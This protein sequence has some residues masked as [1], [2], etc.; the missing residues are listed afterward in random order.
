MLT[1]A[2]RQ[3]LKRVFDIGRPADL[4]DDS[5]AEDGVALADKERFRQRLKGLK[6]PM[7]ELDEGIA[8]GRFKGTSPDL[9]AT[10]K[11][12]N[13]ARKQVSQ[14]ETKRHW[15]EGN[16][17]LDRLEQAVRQLATEAGDRLTRDA[18]EQQLF[19]QRRRFLPEHESLMGVNA[20]PLPG[21]PSGGP[22]VQ[23]W[24]DMRAAVDAC[25]D[26]HRKRDFDAA[27][28]ELKKVRDAVALLNAPPDSLTQA[29]ARRDAL[30]VQEQRFVQ[31]I[32][33]DLYPGLDGPAAQFRAD[34]GKAL[35][36]ADQAIQDQDA[37]AAGGALDTAQQA[38]D[39][40]RA[41]VAGALETAG[42]GKHKDR[43][44]KQA[45]GA[46]AQDPQTLKVLMQRAQGPA[47]IDAMMKALGASAKSAEDKEF[48]KAAILARFDMTSLAGD[49]TTKALPKLYEVLAS[50]PAAHTT[51][52]PQLQHI[53][54]DRNSNQPS[55]YG[56]T[57]L[58]LNI[59]K[60]GSSTQ[61]LDQDDDVKASARLRKTE[62]NTFSHTTLHELGHSV[63]DK[64]GFMGT[65]GKLASYGG[66][67]VHT[68]DELADVAG[69][70]KKFYALGDQGLP[71]AFLREL[72]KCTLAGQS[73]K[74]PPPD[75]LK[76]LSI[77]DRL[78]GL[79]PP[80]QAAL[81]SDKWVQQAQTD[82]DMLRKA[83]GGWDAAVANNLRNDLRRAVDGYAPNAKYIC[84]TI[85]LIF[86]R[87]M[88]AREAAD[89]VL[90]QVV[91]KAPDGFDLDTLAT[92]DAVAWCEWARSH[93]G[94]KYK[95][96]KGGPPNFVVN[97]RYYFRDENN[98]RSYLV[99]ARKNGVSQYQFKAPAE[100]FAEL[101]AAFHL[102][103]LPD[104]HPDATWLAASYGPVAQ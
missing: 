39:D 22:L 44:L 62:V 66:W 52:N 41:A 65:H 25:N 69:T 45:K 78:G 82:R 8:G 51:G 103:K 71:I 95:Y 33:G 81:L 13:L 97:G 100:W 27:L 88:S 68:I 90:D 23:V 73:W 11:E 94:D 79:A 49:L 93:P 20:P 99:D 1:K 34:V 6:A 101:Y 28:K 35:K 54:R 26:A 10:V 104:T 96:Y 40:F 19:D 46:L 47:A 92:H 72:L 58:T 42:T 43:A 98:W 17:A 89:A 16:E 56:E 18:K 70:A 31:G 7:Q 55:T 64:D 2:Q 48:A 76:S 75:V 102:K 30:R 32:D 3:W 87:Q 83:D 85:E 4:Q 15:K 86:T 9:L 74:A 5:E 84:E 61:E 24:D 29:T 12:Y 67:E 80:N 21:K 60:T 37:K 63:D 53:K 38:V 77:A 59:G 91:D 50:V 14:A 57:V 36:L